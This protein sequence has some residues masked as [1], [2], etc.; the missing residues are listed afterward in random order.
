MRTANSWLVKD[1]EKKDFEYVSSCACRPFVHI[2]THFFHITD[3]LFISEI[4]PIFIVC[5]CHISHFRKVVSYLL[6]KYGSAPTINIRPFFLRDT[7]SVAS[8]F[9]RPLPDTLFHVMELCLIHTMPT[10]FTSI[11]SFK[12]IFRFWCS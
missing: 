2:L 5:Q 9:P 3:P 7:A 10:R 8:L 4:R 1:K 12:P 11:F 6:P